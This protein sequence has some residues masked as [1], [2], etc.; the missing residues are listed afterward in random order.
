MDGRPELRWVEI[1]PDSVEVLEALFTARGA[2]GTCWCMALRQTSDEAMTTDK[3]SR[4]LQLIDRVERGDPT[5]L[6]G[7][8]TGAN[9][10]E[11]PVAWVS[12]APRATYHRLS[13]NAAMPG[14]EQDEVWNLGCMW[15]A[16]RHRRTGLP[17]VLIQQAIEHAR[18]RGATVVEAQ[19]IP[20]DGTSYTF[21]GRI[22]V[23][24]A[25]G[26][27]HVAALGTRRHVMRKRL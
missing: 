9:A 27:E 16:S 6:V 26:F 23:F 7:L 4:R 3:A 8:D 17:H 18:A 22:P 11:T 13:K 5:G 25:H 15:V 19:P 21:A 10:D 12:I 20:P 14:T 2:P 1:T 24:E